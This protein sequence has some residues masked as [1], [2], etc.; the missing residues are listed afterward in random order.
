MQSKKL[1]VLIIGAGFSGIC[2]AIM[3][4]QR[5]INDFLILEKGPGLGGTW[6]L[7][8][9]PGAECDIPSALYSYS[10]E[11]NPE[12]AY[13][14]S[15]QQQIL[16]YQEDTAAK[17]NIK[18]HIVLNTEV[19]TSEYIEDEKRWLISTV[20]GQQYDA[21]H[22]VSAI[23]QLHH[24]SRPMITGADR[25][26]GYRFHSAEWDHSVILDK[27]RVAVIGNAA[28]AVQFIPEIAKQVSHL[29]I[30]QRTPN[31]IIPKVND[32]ASDFRLWVSKYFPFVTKIVR[33]R[34]WLIG[35]IGLFPA[36]KGN[37]FSRW[38][39]KDKNRQL[40]NRSI[41]DPKLVAKLTPNYPI[42]AKRVLFSDNYYP[43][44]VRDNVT[45]ETT[46]IDS[47]TESGILQNDG[48]SNDFDVVIYATG[49]KSNPFL[50]P[51]EF[52]GLAGKSLRQAWSNGAHA[53]LGV[54]TNGFPNLFMVYGPNTN[55]GH[56]SIILMI[57][58]QAKYISECI[59]GLDRKGMQALDIK[60]EIET[61]YN[62]A[63]QN[64]LR[65]LAFNDVEDSWYKDGDKITNNWAGGTREYMQ[66]LAKVDWQAYTIS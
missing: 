59:S 60:A 12:W 19:A 51:M 28:S 18:Q 25:Y 48:V 41:K 55:L 21:Q 52:N 16:K 9:Y 13:K 46:G 22:T 31:W 30:F 38:I 1:K 39:L 49:F 58:A 50:A 10:F 42:G 57:E 29:T 61:D 37:R 4:K 45:L 8:N 66:R 47:F 15:G 7:N 3:L 63:L 36:I 56:N 33:F 34:T 40:M 17:Y 23:G 44:L 35:E 43:A 54:V 2:M 24:P 14:W 26:L 20:E 53:Y 62:Q 32:S 5:G 6:R 64:R 11:H 65:K 27:Q